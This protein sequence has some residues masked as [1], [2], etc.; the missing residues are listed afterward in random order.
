MILTATPWIV[1][2]MMVRLAAASNVSFWDGEL[3]V[4]RNLGIIIAGMN[5]EA[6]EC[7]SFVP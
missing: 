2:R 4:D 1:D 5:C 6:R 7:S 3:I